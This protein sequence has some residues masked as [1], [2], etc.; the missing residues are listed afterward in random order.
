M[1]H[2]VSYLWHVPVRHNGITAQ[3]QVNVDD[4]K[5]LQRFSDCLK[6]AGI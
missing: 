6:R 4:G 2:A 1:E 5:Q 3:S